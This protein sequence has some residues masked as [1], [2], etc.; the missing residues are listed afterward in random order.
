MQAD[1][2]R[3][4]ITIGGSS[5]LADERQPVRGVQLDV[6]TP[7]RQDRVRPNQHRVDHPIRGTG[8]PRDRRITGDRLPRAF[9]HAVCQCRRSVR[10]P[11]P[12]EGQATTCATPMAISWSQPGHR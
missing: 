3:D 2:R 12:S 6:F 10:S 9:Q 11:R 7:R 5:Q 8:P 1:Q 4:R